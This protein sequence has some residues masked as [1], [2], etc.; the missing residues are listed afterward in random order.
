MLQK[1]NISEIKTFACFDLIHCDMWGKYR[2]P[3]IFKE[4]YFFTIVDDF[5]RAVCTFLIKHKHEASTCLVDFHKMVQTQFGKRIKRIRCDNGGEFVSNKMCDFYS[6]E[7]IVLETTCAHTPQQN[8]V[9]ERK[10]RY[11]LE[12]TRCDNPKFILLHYPVTVNEIFQCIKVSLIRGHQIN[13]CFI[14]LCFV[15]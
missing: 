15:S 3:S 5:S 8:G 12:T 14:Y 1:K 7:G 11:L 6:R 10:H 4:S 2:T 9:V 13:K